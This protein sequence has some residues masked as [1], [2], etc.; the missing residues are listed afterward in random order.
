MRKGR[1]DEAKPDQPSPL[2]FLRRC[3]NPS[4]ASGGGA[5]S[6]HAATV[7]AFPEVFLYNS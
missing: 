2:F 1:R 7:P 6:K 3:M 4:V 5:W